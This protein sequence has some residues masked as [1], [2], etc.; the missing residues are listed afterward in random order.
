[1]FRELMSSSPRNDADMDVPRVWV[2]NLSVRDSYTTSVDEEEQHYDD[3]PI[4]H[5]SH[6][7]STSCPYMPLRAPV[8][9]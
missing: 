6:A 1:M 4:V 8:L 5:A 3:A 2:R 9:P 7:S